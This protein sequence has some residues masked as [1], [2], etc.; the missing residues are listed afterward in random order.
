ML[1]CQN[2]STTFGTIFWA[3]KSPLMAFHLA[4]WNGLLFRLAKCLYD[5]AASFKN[6]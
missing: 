1:T 5:V 2:L 3:T 4:V 6:T